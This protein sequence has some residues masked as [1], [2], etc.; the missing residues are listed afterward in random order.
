MTFSGFWVRAKS[1]KGV[2]HSAD[3]MDLDE[4]SFRR[5]T[6]EMLNRAGAVCAMADRPD[7]EYRTTTE[8]SD[9]DV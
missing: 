2:W 7:F 1:P 4:E 8:P 5:F 3:A 9:E 6:L